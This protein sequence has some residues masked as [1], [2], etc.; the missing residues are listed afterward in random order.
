MHQY[1]ALLWLYPAPD[2][3]EKWPKNSLSFS[4]WLL[5]SFDIQFQDSFF[6]DWKLYWQRILNS[7]MKKTENW[8][9]INFQSNFK[10][11]IENIKPH[12]YN[13]EI[14]INKFK[15]LYVHNLISLLFVSRR[16]KLT[17]IIIVLLGAIHKGYPFFGQS[18][19]PPT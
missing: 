5:S 14:K 1:S 9:V 19:D 15:Y 18:F 16:S 4:Y 12:G 10:M 2:H 6:F 11:E 17:L 8:V 3:F 7:K 13:N